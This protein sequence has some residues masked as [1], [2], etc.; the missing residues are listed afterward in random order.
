MPQSICYKKTIQ[1]T[2]LISGK[3]NLALVISHNQVSIS[4]LENLMNSLLIEMGG[5][6][7][8]PILYLSLNLCTDNVLTY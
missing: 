3:D 5:Q 4:R 1:I 6:I 7:I 8:L 2:S